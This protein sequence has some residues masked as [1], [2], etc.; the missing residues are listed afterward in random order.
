[1]GYSDRKDAKNKYVEDSAS[2]RVGSDWFLVAR[3]TNVKFKYNPRLL[4]VQQWSIKIL[5]LLT[6]DLSQSF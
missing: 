6:T 1:M 5:W 3:N 4:L 2:K